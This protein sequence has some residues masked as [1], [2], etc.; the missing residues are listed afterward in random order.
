MAESQTPVVDT[1]DREI[2]T[3]RVFDA[4]RELV[5]RAWSEPDLIREWWGPKGFSNTFETFDFQAGGLWRFVMHGPNGAD[6]QNEIRFVEIV[7]PERIVLQHTSGPCFQVTATFADEGGKTR[8]TF[9][10]VFETVE[11][12]NQVKGYATPANEEN[13]DK[14]A[15][16]L[17]RLA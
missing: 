14:L 12:Y 11:T 16:V 2:I 13:M 6:Y 9:H 15:V 10:Q 7:P 5:F 17:A 8:L 1:S 3:T 4:P